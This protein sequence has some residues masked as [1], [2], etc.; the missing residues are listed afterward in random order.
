[1]KQ[2]T[3]QFYHFSNIRYAAPPIGNLRFSAPVA[4]TAPHGKP[5]INDGSNYAICP[6]GSP[7]WSAV[8]T[9][10]LTNGVGSINI[11]AGYQPPNITTLPPV[12]YGTNED[13]LL[14]DVLAPKEIFERRSRGPGAPV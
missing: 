4:P 13:C 2:E 1:M 14:L 8:T 9:E 10:W 5:V 12:Q 3:G 11:S 6:Q 7:A